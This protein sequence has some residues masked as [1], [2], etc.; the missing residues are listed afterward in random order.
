MKGSTTRMAGMTIPAMTTLIVLAKVPRKHLLVLLRQLL[1][2]L[3]QP[4]GACVAGIDVAVIVHADA[5]QGAGVF[6]FLDEPGDLAVLGA[7]DA[8]ALLEARVALVSR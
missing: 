6:G 4:L 7:A 8:D 3:L 2:E 5:F 1:P